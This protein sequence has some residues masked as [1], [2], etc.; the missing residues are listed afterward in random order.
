MKIA[1][2]QRRSFALTGVASMAGRVIR[3]GREA[4]VIIENI[5][6]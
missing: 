6:T 2:V 3:S 5:Q 4:D 1:F